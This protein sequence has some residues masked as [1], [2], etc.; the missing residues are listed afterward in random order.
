MHFL[1]GSSNFR[2]FFWAKLV[3]TAK[4][5]FETLENELVKRKI[6][7]FVENRYIK[8]S[9]K[10]KWKIPTENRILCHVLKERVV[11]ETFI[12]NCSGKNSDKDVHVRTTPWS[13]VLFVPTQFPTSYF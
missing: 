13:H 2:K 1:W 11:F 10:M 4:L 6:H 12:W 5:V 9:H 3:L 7:Y 8:S